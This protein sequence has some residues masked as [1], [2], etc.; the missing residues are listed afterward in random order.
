[1]VRPYTPAYREAVRH[2]CCETGFM[3]RPVDTLFS[4]REVFAD[5]FTRYYTDWEPESCLVAE[6]DGE[7]VGYLAGCL[8]YRLYPVVQASILL[9]LII[10]KV[11]LRVAAQRYNRQTLGFLRWVVLKSLAQTPKR[12]PRAA[13]FHINVLP[14]GRVDNLGLKLI[15]SFLDSLPRRG[16]Q[17]VFGQIQTYDD[18]RPVKI[19]ER[20]GFKLFDQRRVTKFERLEKKAVYVSTFLKELPG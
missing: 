18:R 1:M 15:F 13:H 17:R 5:F 19:F 20:Y 2:I 12:P 4:D 11:A 10:P 3:G 14:R 16:I 6:A 7:V 8:R 9:G